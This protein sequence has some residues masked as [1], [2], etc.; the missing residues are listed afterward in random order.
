MLEAAGDEQGQP[1]GGGPGPPPFLS[2]MLP[3]VPAPFIPPAGSLAG[4][5]PPGR[6]Q[7]PPAAVLH[8]GASSVV[9]KA[10]RQCPRCL[11]SLLETSNLPSAASKEQLPFLGPGRANFSPPHLSACLAAEAREGN[12]TVLQHRS[13]HPRFSHH[14]GGSFQKHCWPGLFIQAHVCCEPTVLWFP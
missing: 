5:L 3:L 10:R 4:A 11:I 12:E 2:P 14:L 7:R 6:E 9:S 8:E 13:Q 1:C